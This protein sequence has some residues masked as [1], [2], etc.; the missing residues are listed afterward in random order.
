MS[1]I[2]YTPNGCPHG[3]PLPKEGKQFCVD[4]QPV[5]ERA[6]PPAEL[7]ATFAAMTDAYDA[8]Q[9]CASPSAATVYVTDVPI[10]ETSHVK[11][12]R[13]LREAST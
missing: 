13:R 11:Q 6:T 7:L 1:E 4:C 9:P 8:P 10:N 12:A 2:V 3:P 5:P